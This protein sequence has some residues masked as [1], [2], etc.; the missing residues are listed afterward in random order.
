MHATQVQVSIRR[1]SDSTFYNGSSFVNQP[2][3]WLIATN[4]NP[5]SYVLPSLNDGAY[6]LR[7]RAVVFGSIGDLTPAAITFTP[8]RP[9]ATGAR[10]SVGPSRRAR[11]TV[12]LALSFWS[13][14]IES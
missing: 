5:W 1:V 14:G 7:A 8:G 11:A 10:L 9:S 4:V 13:G 12:S 3:I 2:E 6:A